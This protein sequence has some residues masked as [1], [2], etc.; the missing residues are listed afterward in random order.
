MEAFY[1]SPA[2]LPPRAAGGDGNVDFVEKI[3]E[4]GDVVNSEGVCFRL[5]RVAFVYSL[6]QGKE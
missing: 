4:P 5:L 6:R 2:I 1:A 3:V